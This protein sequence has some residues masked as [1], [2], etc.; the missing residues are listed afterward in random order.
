MHPQG[1]LWARPIWRRT[2]EESE[3]AEQRTFGRGD[4]EPPFICT[5]KDSCGQ[6]Y[7]EKN[8]R[9]VR[10]CRTTNLREA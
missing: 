6:A 9:G 2:S 5:S 8:V 7:L 3:L 1:L 4:V 10:A